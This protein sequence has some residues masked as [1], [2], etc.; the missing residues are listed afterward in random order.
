MPRILLRLLPLVAALGALLLLP[1]MASAQEVVAP[2]AEARSATSLDGVLV[3]VSGDAPGQTLMQRSRDGVIGPV[4][5]ASEARFYMSPDLGRDASNRLVLTYLRCESSCVAVR[6]DLAGRRTTL[7]GFSRERCSMSTAPALW[8]TRAAYGLSC[9]RVVDGRRVADD[10]RSGLYVRTGTGTPKRLST[11]R[12]A[13]RYGIHDVGAVDLRG[14]R[15]AS[16]YADIYSFSTVQDVD[17]TDRRTFLGAASEGDGD[18][19]ISGLAL[20]T[21]RTSWSLVNSTHAG[22]PNETRLH[23]V[24][25]PCHDWQTMETPEVSQTFAAVDVAAAG[26]DLFLV[27]PGVGIVRHAY[28]PDEPCRT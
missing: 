6:D 15:V 16:V 3:W 2:D 26:S 1:V 13:R 7:K 20:A 10:S 17:G 24:S 9:H 5:G 18:G 23:R 22:D 11:P 19:R 27:V 4:K 28:A 12:Q 21:E 14:S 25:G 8:R